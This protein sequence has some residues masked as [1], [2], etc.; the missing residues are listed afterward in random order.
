MK[1][2][3]PNLPEYQI[4]RLDRDLSPPGEPALWQGVPVL[5][6]DNYLWLD[7]GYRPRVEVKVGYTLRFIYASFQVFEK[8]VRV[9]YV[10][11]QD[12]V[13]KDSCVEFFIDPFPEKEL[14]YI[15]IEAN[16][17]GAMLI[18]F[19]PD[20]DNR[21]PIPREDVPGFEIA[22]SIKGRIEGEHGANDWTLCYRLPLALFEKYYGTEVTPGRR[23]RANFYKCGD[24]TD[25]PHF[26]AWNPVLVEEPDFHRP[27]FFGRLLFL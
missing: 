7:N 11:F 16:A 27:E 18:A 26:G 3:R 2:T 15:N 20:R 12:P 17:A 5:A 14:G 1:P 10:E 24:E 8:R 6:I 22:T 13:W 4:Q 23:A 25:P 19:G 9:Q 21:T